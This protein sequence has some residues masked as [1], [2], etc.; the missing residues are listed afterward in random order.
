MPCDLRTYPHN[1]K[2][3]AFHIRATRAQYVC[4]CRGEC[5]RHHGHRCINRHGYR[6]P[7]M[8][9]KVWL[10]AAHL[11]ACSPPCANPAHVRALCQL[12]H[13]L[14]DKALHLKH[15]AEKQKKAHRS[16]RIDRAQP[17]GTNTPP[18]TSAPRGPIFGLWYGNSGQIAEAKVTVADLSPT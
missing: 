18:Q 8:H 1:W 16:L 13:L 5:G 2:A 3:F 11:C 10:A 6:S 4:E 9:G 17:P 15:R 14:H 7:F 12:C